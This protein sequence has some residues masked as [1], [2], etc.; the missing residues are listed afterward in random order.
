MSTWN[1][2]YASKPK[3][4]RRTF[5]SFHYQEDVTRAHVVRNSWV[6]KDER[7]DAGFFDGSVFESKKRAGE[8][9]LKAF[10]S[11][12][13]NGTTVTCVLVGSQTAYRPWVRYEL[14][15]SFQ[16]G[17]G[18]LAIRIHNIKNFDQQFAVAGPNPFDFLAYQTVQDR[19]HWQENNNGTWARYDKVPTMPLSDVVYDLNWEM[20]HTF[21][22]R[23]PIYD[24]V[25]DNG[26]QNLGA[27]IENAAKQAGK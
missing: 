25:N 2:Q 12:A 18:L 3:Q 5:F 14:V 13:L 19:I 24:W 10:L 16:R 6:T 17:N 26:Y 22:S 21:S 23:F 8:E 9:T 7:Q 11:E 20:H 4:V 15:R 1:Y 27:W